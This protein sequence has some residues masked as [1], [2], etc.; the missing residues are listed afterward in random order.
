MASNLFL[1]ILLDDQLTPLSHPSVFSPQPHE[2]RECVHLLAGGPGEAEYLLFTENLSS[3]GEELHEKMKPSSVAGFPEFS[4]EDADPLKILF[5]RVQVT[6]S[7][8][9]K[10]PLFKV[11]LLH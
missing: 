4:R 2:A 10:P 8:D 3:P 11:T 1:L 7:P 5:I 9:V 6:S